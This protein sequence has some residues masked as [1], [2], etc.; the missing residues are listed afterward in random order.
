MTYSGSPL[1]LEVKGF[2]GALNKIE[3]HLNELKEAIVEDVIE[4]PN[5]KP[6]SPR[7]LRR[8]SRES[9][10]LTENF[11]QGKL[12]ITFLQ[13][14]LRTAVIAR[15]LA[16]RAVCEEIP[17]KQNR[18]LCH[19]PP[20]VPSSTPL[21]ISMVSHAY[22]LYPF[23][24]HQS[25]PWMMSARSV[26]RLRR[27][28]EWLAAN[29]TEDTQKTGGLSM[30][31][32]RLMT[33]QEQPADLRAVLLSDYPKS[34]LTSRVVHA[35]TGHLLLASP[36]SNRVDIAPPLQGQCQITTIL[37]W[38]NNCDQR[39]RVFT[40]SLPSAFLHS[41]PSQQRVLHRLIYHGID[42]AEGL[43]MIKLELVLPDLTIK[44]AISP[45]LSTDDS[46]SVIPSFD[47]KCWIGQKV[48]TDV[49]MPDRTMD[50]QFS[51]FDS[52]L[53]PKQ[54]WPLELQTHTY[55]LKA[56]LTY[57][58]RNASQPDNPLTFV[59]EGIT[60]MLHSSCA[61]RQ[62]VESLSPES[63]VRVVSESI[64]DLDGAHKS[65]L[66]QVTCEDI[67]AD[68]EWTSFLHHCD[69]ISSTKASN[70]PRTPMGDIDI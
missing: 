52:V 45:E 9:G 26:F 1:S 41:Q 30:G 50:I 11:G 67:V 19:I 36:L 24:S 22:S 43:Q 70:Q 27:V 64:L 55:N 10:A 8:I 17:T 3:K 59:Y 39:N 38:M 6:I 44:T 32:G 31:R 7:L 16:A 65:T 25:M 66:C 37:Q 4:F 29:A 42:V 34:P 12:R 69:K 28:E 46:Q 60:Y 57:Q 48:D 40:P 18:V 58:D 2:V 15:R 47:T 63:S 20:A 54:Q 13:D 35:T 68:D 62:N 53:L 33:L 21:P 5:S 56:F 61:V 49:M 51:T 14:K 23:L